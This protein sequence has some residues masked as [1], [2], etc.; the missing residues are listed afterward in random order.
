M[1]A[2]ITS[3]VTWSHVVARIPEPIV[4]V[5]QSWLTTTTTPTEITITMTQATTTTTA[6]KTA[7]EMHSIPW[8]PYVTVWITDRKIAWKWNTYWNSS[9]RKKT[10]NFP[11]KRKDREEE[12]YT[13]MK[14]MTESNEE[15]TNT[16]IDWHRHKYK[17]EQ[18]EIPTKQK[19]A[20]AKNT[21]SDEN[22]HSIWIHIRKQNWSTNNQL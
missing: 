9:C 19:R 18:N 22:L 7:T 12:M 14:P 3:N 17:M 13:K 15:K 1:N 2:I 20:K 11:K 21:K 16:K 6:A 10:H 5:W 8:P 4:L